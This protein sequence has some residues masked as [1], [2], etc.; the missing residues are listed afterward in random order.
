MSD[1][2]RI[3]GF[4]Y[5]GTAFNPAFVTQDG[6]VRI[7]RVNHRKWVVQPGGVGGFEV[8]GREA[9]IREAK[10][11]SAELDEGNARL[12]KRGKELLSHEPPVKSP[13]KSHA[14]IKREVDEILAKGNVRSAEDMRHYHVG[15]AGSCGTS[16]CLAQAEREEQVIYQ[17]KRRPHTERKAHTTAKS[18]ASLRWD[19]AVR[20]RGEVTARSG[21][22]AFVQPT[23][24]GEWRWEV[25]P[26]GYEMIDPKRSIGEGTAN[27]KAKAKAAASRV[28]LSQ[29]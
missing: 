28:L 14:Q 16:A 3:P 25:K 22:R 27:S 15:H 9:A 26:I 5:V 1:S 18:T 24:G 4:R 19:P 6:R 20:G 2:T 13:K 21:F 23:D 29:L 10:R 8:L 17:P 7:G 11:V 12:L